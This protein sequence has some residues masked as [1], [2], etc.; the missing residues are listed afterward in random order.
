YF[1]VLRIPPYLGRVFHGSDEHGPNSAPYIV[2]SHAYWDVHFHDDPGV[3]GLTV[4]VNKHPF[5]IVGVAPPL[6]HGT[7]VFGTPDFFV[8][9]VNQ[10]QV[11]G[12]NALNVRAQSSVFMALGHLKL[13]VT[14]D[15]AAA[16]LNSIGAYL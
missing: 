4:R 9:L 13:G 15:Q 8:P 1:D 2:L 3:G 11:E 6:F 5:I 10:E 7:L 16:D 14:P 12:R